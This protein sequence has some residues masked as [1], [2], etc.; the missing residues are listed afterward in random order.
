MRRLRLRDMMLLTVVQAVLFL[1]IKD[2]VP[3]LGTGPMTAP[4]TPRITPA[5]YKTIP[6]VELTDRQIQEIRRQLPI[7][8]SITI[9]EGDEVF[10]DKNGKVLTVIG[11]V[12]DSFSGPTRDL[13][14]LMR[15]RARRKSLTIRAERSPASPLAVLNPRSSAHVGAFPR[16]HSN[17]E[18][19]K[20]AHPQIR[21]DTQ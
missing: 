15:F 20:S 3:L 11:R 2:N 17:E 16:A 1:V 6:A 21:K 18:L 7:G 5:L 4:K 9:H 14:R 10:F 12:P 8:R 13:K 19:R